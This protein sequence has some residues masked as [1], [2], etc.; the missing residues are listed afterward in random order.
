[1]VKPNS[2]DSKSKP[3][4]DLRRFF[5][6]KSVALVGATEN[7]DR[8]AGR[9]LMRMMNFGYE[10]EIFPVNP[11]FGTVRGLKCYPTLRDLPKAPDH[12][13]IVVP[14]E[15]VSSILEDCAAREVSFATIFT[16]G[17]AETGTSEGRERQAD[18]LSLA[19]RS[20]IRIMG[21]NCNGLIS[22]VDGFAM[23]TSGTIAGPRK[24]PGNIGVVSQS[25][26]AGQT[27][28]M[29]RAQDLGLSI[30]YQVSCGNS[31][32]LN[33]LDF[34]EFMIN[35]PATDVIMV[36]AE[37]IPDGR[38]LFEVAGL[39]AEREKP[40]VMI[41][42]GRTEAGSRAAASHTGALAGA[43]S[44]CDAALR[45]C[46]I[47]R[48]DDCNELYEIA[49][50]LRTRK[51]PRGRRAGAT[52][53][54]GGNAVLLV[55]LAA[56]LG[57]SWPEFRAETKAQLVDV[58]P[59]M[60]TAGNP[61]DLSNAAIGKPE[62]FQRCIE[63]I[64][65]DDQVDVVIPVF[66]MSPAG[67]MRQAAESARTESKP[68]VLLWIGGC[69]DDP[70][71]SAKGIIE[72][73]IPVYRNSL[74]CLKAVR[75]AMSYGE[76]LGNR[77]RTSELTKPKGVD[78][79]LARQLL[80]NSKDVLTERESK[81]VLSAYGFQAPK[82]GIAR[83]AEEAVCIAREI[84]KPV[85]LKIE[86]ADILHKT[87]AGAVCLHVSGDDAVREAFN[88]VIAAAQSYKPEA[89]LDGVSVQE[90]APAGLEIMLGI[91]VDPIFGPVVVAGLGGIYV[92]VLRDVAYRVAPI[93]M[94]EAE[95]MLR[96]L[97]GYPL[98]EG[99]RGAPRRDIQRLCDLITRLSWLGHNH[100]DDLTELDIN[101]LVLF[102][103]GGGA[104]VVDALII[105]RERD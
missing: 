95:V 101:P 32:D 61:V 102:E 1:M 68:V 20:G 55:D 43:D 93:D 2:I 5:G 54:S 47:I 97:R 16:G 78:V 98:L 33:I 99:V 24:L 3:P 13:G 79:D 72:T 89:K 91:T 69:T 81:A 34:M 96:E 6:P 12:V 41:K 58:L 27:N 84:G 8:F 64:S 80:R 19:R 82:D 49:M 14:A 70:S 29:W 45:Q 73:G 67:D 39:A 60:G 11:R 7:L 74:S 65:A 94:R 71:F 22:F 52:T 53:I 25:G 37:H 35:D 59:K 90:M 40:I 103:A 31:A 10:G 9:V 50:L 48:V 23:T 17:F 28:V 30:S 26:G 38:R 44:I 51:W 66:T 46:G 92:E 18:I 36:L 77:I 15:K 4:A 42:L 85:A 86:S 104:Q 105:K 100:Q 88:R 56:D 87:E 62:I 57:I 76:F 75:A 63:A 83:K 21:P